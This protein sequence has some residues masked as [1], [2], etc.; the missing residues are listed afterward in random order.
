M[1][2]NTH[3]LFFVISD[4]CLQTSFLAGNKVPLKRGCWSKAMEGKFFRSR[5]LEV[6]QSGEA[7]A[8]GKA[9]SSPTPLFLPHPSLTLANNHLGASLRSRREGGEQ[10]AADVWWKSPEVWCLSH[11]VICTTKCECLPEWGRLCL[12]C[13]PDTSCVVWKHHSRCS[14]AP[15]SKWVKHQVPD[16]DVHQLYYLCFLFSPTT[17]MIYQVQTC[18]R[19]A[20]TADRSLWQILLIFS[21]RF[22]R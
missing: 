22:Q 7:S 10:A 17:V 12:S 15:V 16:R 20:V 4:V 18:R 2:H 13:R 21:D 9:N 14:T 3:D 6:S 1:G 11:P 19:A 5:I 8:A